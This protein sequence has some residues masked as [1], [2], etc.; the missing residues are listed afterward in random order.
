MAVSLPFHSE[1]F[2]PLATTSRLA[3]S[4]SCW[5]SSRPSLRLA[6]IVSRASMPRASRNLDALVQLV[7][8]LR[9]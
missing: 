8:P 5:A 9:W 4:A 3:A 6:G 1:I 7:Q 2:L